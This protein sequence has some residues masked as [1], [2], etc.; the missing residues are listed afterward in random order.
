MV[1]MMVRVMVM[2]MEMEMRRGHVTVSDKTSSG[3]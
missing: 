2:V 1:G 3:I